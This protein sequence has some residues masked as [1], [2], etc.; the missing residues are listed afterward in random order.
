MMKQQMSWIWCSTLKADGWQAAVMKKEL[1]S[2]Q[3]LRVRN[4]GK[5][6]GSASYDN[7]A[8]IW[9][10]KS[11]KSIVLS[12]HADDVHFI[13]FHPD[14]NRAATSSADNTIVLWD[15]ETGEVRMVY[16]GHRNMV[17]GLLFTEKGERLISA[18]RDR[19]LRVRD[20]KTGR[21]L[22]VL[23]GHT[24]SALS[25]TS[26]EA[27]LFSAG[28]DGTVRQWQDMT[29]RSMQILDLNKE[30]ISAAVSPD[31]LKT[32]VGFKDGTLELFTLPDLKPLWQK[33]D[34]HTD[35][36]LRLAFSQDGLKLV[37]AS[38]DKT[39]KVWAVDDRK[40]LHTLEGHE[41]AVHAAAFSPDSKLVAT[42]S[43]DGNIGLFDLAAGKKDFFKAHEGEYVNSVAFDQ[44]T[45]RLLSGGD[46]GYTRLWD[47]GK[48]PPSAVKTFPQLQEMVM[49]AAIS[50]DGKWA[51]SV[52]RDLIVHIY[53]VETGQIRYNLVGHEDAVYRAAFSPDSS[54]AATVSSDATVRVWD[55]ET[56]TELF[57]LS[58]PSHGGWPVPLWDFA[59]GCGKGE[60]GEV[61]R[62]WIVVPLTSGRLV[63]YDLG[64]NV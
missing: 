56:G 42:A 49:W 30:L 18:S 21:T 28:N 1:S 53:A 44:S 26:R 16:R 38:F 14:G 62:C 43:Y 45:G 48:K 57:T 13:A 29:H 63:V 52:G 59:F 23:Q 9:N 33:P 22:H 10:L 3:C 12:G 51:A 8:R 25:V 7:T 6:L 36:I 60:A 17:F 11:G 4:S 5:M 58:L 37:S 61:G 19:T 20:T 2:G 55:L 24:A 39:A 32:A 34:A 40:A 54:Q 31:G 50:P 41:D 35:A 64:E 47:I 27:G 46:D 15:T